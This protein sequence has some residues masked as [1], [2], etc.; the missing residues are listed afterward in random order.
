MGHA[1]KVKNKDGYWTNVPFV[2]NTEVDINEADRVRAEQSRVEAENARVRAEEA[3]VVTFETEKENAIADIDTAKDRM[4]DEFESD[5]NRLVDNNLIP[6]A[7]KEIAKSVESATEISVNTAKG[8]IT[9]H[10][11]TET[12]KATTAIE[13][14]TDKAVGAMEDVAESAIEA[15]DTRE[16]LLWTNPT[17]TS[18]FTTADIKIDNHTDYESFRIEF[19]RTC[20]SDDN[21]YG[22]LRK[23]GESLLLRLGETGHVTTSYST[24]LDGETATSIVGRTVS[25]SEDGII[26]IHGID[27]VNNSYCI[28]YKIYGIKNERIAIPVPLPTT[29]SD[30]NVANSLKGRVVG[31]GSV[32]IDDISPIEHTL[33]VKVRS[34]NI[35][36]SANAT[37]WTQSAGAWNDRVTA[38]KYG[39]GIKMTAKQAEAQSWTNGGLTL[40]LTKDFLGKTLTLSFGNVSFSMQ[41]GNHKTCIYF[42]ICKHDNYYMDSQSNMVGVS[43]YA[44]ANVLTATIPADTDYETYPYLRIAF[45][46]NNGG[47]VSVGDYAIYEDIMVEEGAVSEPMYTEYVNVGD[48]HVDTDIGGYPINDDGT[49]DGVKSVYP[50]MYVEAVVVDGMVVDVDYNKDANKVVASL[51]ERIA[52]LEAAIVSK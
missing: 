6:R 11:E 43:T 42:V 20:Y 37:V 50:T 15:L 13:T 48:Y 9:D 8:K 26:T 16:V 21:G 36:D 23:M 19:Y 1:L 40:G 45:Y 51:E 14:L 41:S 47:A 30:E 27:S 4:I 24:Y 12:A 49:V 10:A 32:Y 2:V 7:T 25:V 28:P 5:A 33:D 18:R 35:L 29:M 46:I 17:P 52:A 22:V 38:E 44:N 39:N 31:E 3:R 34:K